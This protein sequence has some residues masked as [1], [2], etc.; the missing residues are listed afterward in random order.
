MDLCETH[1]LSVCLPE[2][3][4]SSITAFSFGRFMNTNRKGLGRY[5][6]QRYEREMVFTDLDKLEILAITYGLLVAN[7]WRTLLSHIL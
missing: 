3:G 4:V 6:M 1:M 5:L 7:I 2:E